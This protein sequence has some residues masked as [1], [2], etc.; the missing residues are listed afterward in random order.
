M[1]A[2][3]IEIEDGDPE[4]FADIVAYVAQ[5]LRRGSPASS[6]LDPV[7][8]GIVEDASIASTRS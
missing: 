4:Q 5:E 3:V 8:W 2:V 7:Q 1:R 6:P